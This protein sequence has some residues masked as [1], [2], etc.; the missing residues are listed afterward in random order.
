MKPASVDFRIISIGTLAAHPLWGERVPVRTGHATITLIRSGKSIILVDPGLPDQAVVARLGERSNLR[1]SDITHV[2]LTSFKPDTSRGL[3]AFEHAKWWVSGPERE[4]VGIRLISMLKKA[5]ADGEEKL[6][7]MLERDISHLQRCEEAPDALAAG[8][9]L[10]P[11]PGVTP[12]L[13]GLLIE[14]AQATT[15]VCGD[16]V[17]TVEHLAEGKVLTVCDDMEAARS[18]FAEAVETA[19]WL[20]PGRDNLVPSPGRV[21]QAATGEE[22]EDDDIDGDD[23][24]EL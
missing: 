12:G 19:D 6:R 7:Q 23:D 18:S 10:F 15:I 14:H 24:D 2:F 3:G 22:D 11:L 16:A 21:V 8:V 1:A 13:A 5:S 9:D 20:I 17:A 4:R